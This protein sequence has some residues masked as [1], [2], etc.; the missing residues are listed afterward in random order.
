MQPVFFLATYSERENVL[1]MAWRG[2]AQCDRRRPLLES[3]NVFRFIEMLNRVH[4]P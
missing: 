1:L 2:E 4:V 3:L